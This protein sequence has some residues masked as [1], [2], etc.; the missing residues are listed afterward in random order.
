MY[1]DLI[2]LK[3]EEELVSVIYF[4]NFL[5]MEVEGEM[6]RLDSD[7]EASKEMIDL[8]ERIVRGYYEFIL[9]I[10]FL[11]DDEVR[12]IFKEGYVSLL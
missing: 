9:R 7:K 3:L 6:L 4:E 12:V 1:I 2:L 11:S 8:L 5:V 10:M